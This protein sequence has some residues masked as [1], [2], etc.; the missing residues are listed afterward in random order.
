MKEMRVKKAGPLIILS[1]LIIYLTTNNVVVYAQE[2]EIVDVNRQIKVYPG[3]LV[4]VDNITIKGFIKELAIYLSPDEYQTLYTVINDKKIAMQWGT[5]KNEYIGFSLYINGFQGNISLTRV[6]N[7]KLFLEETTGV[8]VEIPAYL[9]TDYKI[10][11]ITAKVDFEYPVSN[12]NATSPKDI[13]QTLIEN[14]ISLNYKAKNLTPFNTDLLS[15]TFR[16]SPEI[17]WIKVERLTRNIII[18][19]LDYVTVVDNFTLKYIGR[20]ETVKEWAPYLLPNA[21]VISVKDSLGPLNY[22]LGL[23]KLRYPL[24][25]AF[26]PGAI[27]NQTKANVIITSQINIT[28]LGTVNKNTGKIEISID[29]LKL[30]QLLI[31]NFE[32][33]ITINLA[34][35]VHMIP[36]PDTIV[37][38]GEGYDYVF[39]IRNVYPGRDLQ[40]T[41]SGTINPYL[42]SI[43]SVTQVIF[44]LLLVA[45]MFLAYL[46]FS[47]QKPLKIQRIPEMS[48]FI[49]LIEELMLDNEELERLEENLEKGFIKKH[50]YNLRVKSLKS[51]IQSKENYLKSLSSSLMSQYPET[52]QIISTINDTY[53]N[54]LKEQNNLKELKYSYKTKKIQPVIYRKS[55]EVYTNAIK[56]NKAKIDN[57]LAQLREKYLK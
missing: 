21:K 37:K 32:L 30:N 17:P 2:G 4:I 38:H 13:K 11:N 44:I 50:D 28:E 12:V 57:L 26:Y 42:N 16:P 40:V 1:L 20:G 47:G 43:Y 53:F 25:N 15:F 10:A 6:Y 18:D 5:V 3:F 54:L 24:L 29:A 55:L 45:V 56:A 36:T 14:R 35:D 31:D 48:K 51:G 33:V 8:K 46:Y 41:L 39:K 19:N 52:K 7:E 27:L 23:I 22:S 49:N 9:M 34:R